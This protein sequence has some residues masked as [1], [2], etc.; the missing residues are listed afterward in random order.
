MFVIYVCICM[1][2][3][4]YK[5]ILLY[6]IKLSPQSYGSDQAVIRVRYITHNTHCLISVFSWIVMKIK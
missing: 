6:C 2:V 1:C 4:M 5:Y 3:C